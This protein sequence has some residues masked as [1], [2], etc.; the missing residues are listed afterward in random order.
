M[1]TNVTVQTVYRAL[2][3]PEPDICLLTTCSFRGYQGPEGVVTV[4]LAF[5]VKLFPSNEAQRKHRTKKQQ[6]PD[7]PRTREARKK[8]QGSQPVLTSQSCKRCGKDTHTQEQKPRQT[9]R[10]KRNKATPL[11]YVS[12]RRCESAFETS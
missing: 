8:Q 1:P 6:E 3:S 12:S 11:T 4:L 9:Q 2:T 7:R 5:I 10:T